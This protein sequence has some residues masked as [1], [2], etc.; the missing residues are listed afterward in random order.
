[1]KSAAGLQPLYKCCTQVHDVWQCVKLYLYVLGAMCCMQTQ[2][3]LVVLAPSAWYSCCLTVTN[4]NFRL[5]AHGC[6]TV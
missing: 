3:C 6:P 4:V 2:P 1:M 5:E